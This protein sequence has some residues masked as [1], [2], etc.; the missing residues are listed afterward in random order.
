[1]LRK[2]DFRTLGLAEYLIVLSCVVTVAVVWTLTLERVHYERSEA[3]HDAISRNA[4]LALGFEESVARI[5]KGVDQTVRLLK[6]QYERY[7]RGMRVS[8]VVTEGDLADPI[9]ANVA[10]ADARGQLIFAKSQFAAAD[11]SDREY[12]K[13]HQERHS[14]ALFIGTPTKGRL[15]GKWMIPISRRIDHP[16]GSFGGVAMAGIDAA[17]FTSFYQ[18]IDLGDKGMV[19][20]VGLDGVPRA[21]REGTTHSFGDGSIGRRFLAAL[22]DVPIGNVITPGALDG[23]PRFVSYRSMREYPLVVAVGHAEDEALAAFNRRANVYYQSAAAGT[24]LLV[25]FACMLLAAQFRNRRA[26]H[27]AR[28]S[29][30]RFRAIFEQATAGIARSD[31]QLHILEVNHRF[32]EMVGYTEAELL[33]KTF[34]DITH[35]AD[36]VK[37]QQ[38]RESLCRG[39]AGR[40]LSQL[41]KRYVRK[42]GVIVW[43]AIAA[44]LVRDAKGAPDYFVTVIQDVTRRKRAEQ[45]LQESKEQFQQLAKHVPEA[46]WITDLRRHSMI[47]V[48]PAFERIHGAPLR[49]MRGV[50]RA[51]KDTL[52]P[53]DRERALEAHRNM[54]YGP[55]EVRYRIVR[56]DGAIR[57]VRACGYP[58]EDSR[59]VVY[60][61]AGTIEDVTE[62]HELENR[63]QHQA[64]FDSLTGL[65][66]RVLFFDRLGQAL[67]QARRTSH[68]VGL[69]FVDIDRFKCVNDTLGH[70]IGDKLLQHVARCLVRSIRAEDTVARL[71]GDEFGIILPHA[72]KPE[73]AAVIAQ[74]ALA[75][76][77]EPLQLEAHEVVVTGSIGVALSSS[78]G[79]DAETLV[80]NADTAMFRAKNAGRNA[81]EFYTCTMNE[82]ALEQLH[83]ERRLRRAV[84]RDEFMLHYQTKRNIVT[85][86]LTGCEGLLRWTGPGGRVVRPAEFVPL[87]EESGLIM[88]VG[89]WVV[90]S[91]CRQ[92]AQWHRTGLP[93]LPVA[94]NISA[95]QFNQR[96]LADII[97]SALRENAVDGRHLEIELTESTAMQN[98]EDA[99]V[100]LGKLKALGVRIAIDD[101]GTGHSSLSYLKRL[102]IDVL[103]IDRSFVTGLPSSEDD[104]SITKAIITMAHSLGL[105]VVAEG[106]ET[107]EQLAF[108]AENGCDEV[109]G[110]LLS[111]PLAAD[112]LA[113]MMRAYSVMPY[114]AETAGVTLH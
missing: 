13:V 100:T 24:G 34:A 114:G 45:A 74:K 9:V 59:G 39:S 7:G 29:E 28:S 22:P 64:H 40:A 73:N 35:P 48:S 78:D 82:R 49:T 2:R 6:H 111:R 76:L 101:F 70:H 106:V 93:P 20:L 81:Y 55:V 71:G 8:D 32:C 30:A 75:C 51:W 15:T 83:L 113:G 94:V 10:I 107:E 50:W 44:S 27:A 87:L 69:L 91:A 90:R 108:L 19:V 1:V 88:Q 18:R 110:Y 38:F 95:K 62:R 26:K 52:H 31:M 56:P 3:V 79:V 85:G 96:N 37:S 4:N 112:D 41:E 43:V 60:R 103:K 23:V 58:V 21:M 53:E 104:A 109:Q 16:D 92:I 102:P 97:E 11:V 57:W 14:S 105:K 89:E 66:N 46:F 17:Y 98:A 12:F 25:A 47:Y 5:L 99:I 63:L 68:T 72:E 77:A 54:A 80:K 65:P 42:D 86:E 36:I 33:G 67:T 61:V 84:E